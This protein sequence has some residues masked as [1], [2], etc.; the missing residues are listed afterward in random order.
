MNLINNVA[1]VRPPDSLTVYGQQ[2]RCLEMNDAAW[3]R[4]GVVRPVLAT[5]SIEYIKA[6]RAR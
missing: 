2:C 6:I 4:H 5:P 3:R 1:N